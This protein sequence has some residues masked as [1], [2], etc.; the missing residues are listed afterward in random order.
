MIALISPLVAACFSLYVTLI[1]FSYLRG[2]DNDEPVMDFLSRM[3]GWGAAIVFGMHIDM[4]NT[5]VVPF[6]NH[7]G[8]DLA[9]V[10]GPAFNSASALDNMANG[11]ATAF[12]K[13]MHDASG[14]KESIYAALAILLIWLFAGLFMVVAIAYILLA[15]VALGILLAI[16]PLFIVAALFPASRDLFKNWTGQCLN[17]AFLVMLFSF[18]AQIEI[19]MVNSVIPADLS[20]SAVMKVCL[21]CAVMVFVSLNLPSLA[22]SLAGGVGISSMVGKFRQLPNLRGGG[23]PGVAQGGNNTMSPTGSGGGRAGGSLAP[24]QKT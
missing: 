17:Y 9:G 3:V 20:I 16:G 1:L 19:A 4:Y 15:K 22:S 5:Y 21:I 13:I 18:A 23:N 12:A 2:E 7:L 6:V 14:I 10:V 11:F 24:E 8:D